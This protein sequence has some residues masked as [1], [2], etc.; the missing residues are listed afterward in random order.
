M[1][2][3]GTEGGNIAAQMTDSVRFPAMPGVCYRSLGH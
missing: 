3:A 1:S 2:I